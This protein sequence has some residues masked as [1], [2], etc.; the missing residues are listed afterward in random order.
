VWPRANGWGFV[1]AGWGISFATASERRQLPPGVE[2]RPL[3]GPKPVITLVLGWRARGASPA[4]L[5]L[6][7][8]VRRRPSRALRPAR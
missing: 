7:E 1:A 6:V 4:A 2:L 3:H 8:T 5:R